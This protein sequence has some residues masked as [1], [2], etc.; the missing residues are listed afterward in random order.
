MGHQTDQRFSLTGKVALVTG[1]GRGLGRSFAL[2]LAGAGADLVVASRTVEEVQQVAGEVNAMGRSAIACRLDVSKPGAVDVVVG[3]AVERFGRLDILVNNAGTSVRR[4]SLDITEADWDR[5]V[6]TNV[7]GA[8][9]CAQAAGRRMVR[10]QS[11]KI[12]NIA[13][14]LA[15]V[16]S[17]DLAVYCTSKA[18]VTHMTRALALEW[19][20]YQVNVNA[21]APTTTRTP[22]MEQR[23]ADPEVHGSY[24]RN[25]PM[26]RVGVPD[27]LIGALLFLAA[28]ASDFMTGQTII[29]DGGFTAR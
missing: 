15:F 18:A 24:V 19:A 29:I 5:V 14:A 6:N 28:P 25:I 1:A 10:Q 7:K 2:A 11:G 17:Q 16:A 27:D 4:P 22:M 9:F 20:P 13:S 26:G 21:I 23:L 8:F 3:Q 12:I